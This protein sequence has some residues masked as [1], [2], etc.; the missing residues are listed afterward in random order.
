VSCC[1]KQLVAEARESSG[2]QR[3]ENV[4]CWKP[5]PSNGSEDV[6]VYTSVCVCN[7]V[8]ESVVTRCVKESNKSSHQPKTPSIV[9]HTRDSIYLTVGERRK[10]DV[11][12]IF[13]Q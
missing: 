5:L 10:K 9:T 1:C 11:S 4:R 6:T 7:S 13:V 3:K 12:S 8:L 2:T